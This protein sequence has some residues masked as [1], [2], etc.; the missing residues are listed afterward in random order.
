MR[1][2]LTSI[3]ALV[4][5]AAA[6]AAPVTPRG[7]A[8][9]ITAPADGTSITTGASFPFSY[10]DSNSC[11]EGYTPITVW[12]TDAQPTGL[13]GNGDLPAGS[14]IEE[15]GSYLIGNFGLSPL[16][17]FP[18]PP[19]SLV[20]PDISAYAPGTPLYLTVVETALAGTCPPGNQPAS[21]GFTTIGLVVA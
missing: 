1:L 11:H 20:I 3:V 21:Y 10:A 13:D 7:G 18:V 2:Q 17:G 15:F 8:G 4:G 16:P 12:L 9:S 6:A 19:T 14:F 5:L